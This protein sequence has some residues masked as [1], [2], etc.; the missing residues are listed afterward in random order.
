MKEEEK[1]GR[2]EGMKEWKSWVK[3]DEGIKEGRKK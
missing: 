2:R 1:I 3:A